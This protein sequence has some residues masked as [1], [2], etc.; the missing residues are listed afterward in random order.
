MRSVFL[1]HAA[2]Q[3]QNISLQINELNKIVL[4]YCIHQVYSE[5]QGYMKYLRDVSTLAVP[6][7]NP[8]QASQFDRKDFKLKPWF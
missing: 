2:N 1:Q 8:I 6:L 7:A 5:A 3:E 4:E